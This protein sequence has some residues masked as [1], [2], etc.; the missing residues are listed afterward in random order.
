MDMRSMM[1]SWVAA[2][3]ENL[4]SFKDFLS[5]SVLSWFWKWKAYSNVYVVT[6]YSLSVQLV[7]A[8][9]ADSQVSRKLVCIFRTS[10]LEG[11]QKAIMF[12]KMQTYVLRAQRIFFPLIYSACKVKHLGEKRD[13]SSTIQFWIFSIP[14]DICKLMIYMHSI[15]RLEK[16]PFLKP[17]HATIFFISGVRLTNCAR[18]GLSLSFR[19]IAL[20]ALLA[21][22]TQYWQSGYSMSIWHSQSILL[23][24]LQSVS[25]ISCTND[26]A[27]QMLK[28]SVQCYI[29]FCI[30]SIHGWKLFLYNT[31]CITLVN[32]TLL[33]FIE[34]V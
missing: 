3:S 28:V 27:L 19:L 34:S 8:F 29:L 7:T 12:H 17:R 32:F 31:G 16:L 24:I 23:Y 25:I 15:C 13:K 4:V 10:A 14:K 21:Q 11:K 22:C 20:K 18:I 30:S 6:F 5:S 9:N 2:S 33:S 1:D 26:S